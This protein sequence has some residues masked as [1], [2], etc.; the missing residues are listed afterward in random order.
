MIP[1]I[2]HY[3]W[4]SGDPIPEE[5]QGWMNT[6][7][8][9]L[10]DWEFI[11]WDKSRFD[12]NTVEWVRQAYEA[13]KYAFAADYIRHYAV[14]N[15]GGFYMD[16]D[17]EVVK[18][19]D[20]LLSRRYVLGAETKTAIEAGVF[21]AEKSSPLI[22]SCLDWYSNK[23]FVNDDGSYCMITCPIVMFRSISV[24]HEIEISSE[25]SADENKVTLLPRDFLTVKSSTTG[26][27][28]K[29]KNTYTVHHFAG[30]WVS[31]TT[32]MRER[33]WWWRGIIIP[34]S[35]LSHV[36][37]KLGGKPYRKFKQYT[38]DKYLKKVH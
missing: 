2:I 8:K 5:L 32:K 18:N 16:M 1:K 12:I 9:K 11:L 3:C 23:N 33:S 22:K 10:P 24:N 14:Y 17:I 27:V 28:K 29:T 31:E 37:E 25:I 34:L 38:W 35:S 36:L 13:K 7:K 21:G 19:L 20:G 30:S 15:Y 6:W 4:L 26:V